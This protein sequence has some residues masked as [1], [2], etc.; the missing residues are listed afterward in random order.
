MNLLT[1][2]IDYNGIPIAYTREGLG[3]AVVLLHGF[4]E[5]KAIWTDYSHELAKTYTVLSIDLLGH[6]DSGQMGDVHTM[7]MIATTVK[8]ILDKEQLKEAVIIGHSMGG[9]A[10][11]AFAAEFP[12]L[13]KGV[14][15]FH[16]TVYPDSEE[17][18]IQRMQSVG[19]VKNDK[20]SYVN[21]LIPKLFAPE[22]LTKYPTQVALMKD[23]GRKTSINGICAA[24]LGMSARPDYTTVMAGLRCP[25][26]FILGKQ[27]A[28]LPIDT[29]LPILSIPKQAQALI[30]DEVGHMGF[31]EAADACLQAIKAFLTTCYPVTVPTVHGE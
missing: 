13:L 12:D 9:Y 28:I 31:I 1:K 25:V 18:K 10:G 30:L 17:R 24:L 27:D 26:L 2:T 4:T 7:E 16:S 23:I 8:A 29:T 5:S 22:S 11:L 6:G 20:D 19:I 15:L 21:L 3:N 14:G